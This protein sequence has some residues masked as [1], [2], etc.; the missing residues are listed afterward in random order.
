MSVAL[1]DAAE[2]H[3]LRPDDVVEG[4]GSDASLGLANAEAAR[5]LNDDGPN[6]LE[7]APK[8]SWIGRLS[9]ELR[10]PLVGLL[11]V[12]VAISLAAWLLEGRHGF[13]YDAIAITAILT[14]NAVI[15]AVQSHR[16]DNA[17]AALERLSAAQ[18]RVVRDG[19]HRQ[20]PAT[21]VVVGDL[22]ALRAGDTLPADVRVLSA[23][24]LRTAE[25]SLTGESHPVDK[26]ADPV[27]RSLPIADRASM[28]YSGTAVVAGRGIGVVVATGMTTEVGQIASMLIRTERLPTPLE[29]D[30][31]GLGRL[32]GSLVVAVAIVVMAVLAMTSDVSSASDAIDVLLLG[33]SLAVAAVPEGLPAVL[34]VVLAISVQRMASRNALVKRLLSAETL[35]AATVICTDKTGTLTRNEM[36]VR[37]AVVGRNRVDIGGV[38]Y[39]PAGEISAAGQSLDPPVERALAVLLG[40]AA[41][42]GDS[43]IEAHPDGWR[44]VG[45]PT[46][47]A[48]VAAAR[49]VGDVA[50]V[51][52]GPRL[53]EL[54][55]TSDRKRMSVLLSDTDGDIM[56]TKGAP[57]VLIT[58]CRTEWEDTGPVVLTPER[59]K[60][61]LD[62]VEALAAEGLRTM[63][64]ARRTDVAAPLAEADETEL[65]WLGAVGIDDPP[66]PEAGPAV[67]AAHDSGIRVVMV[68]GD[69]P[70]TATRIAQLV[71]IAVPGDPVLTGPEL[72][73]LDDAQ[74]AA[75]AM[76]TPVFARVTPAHKLRL[77][78]AMQSQGD[79]VAM[80]G[81]GVNDAPALKAADLGTAMGCTGT[82]VAREASEMILLDDNFATIVAAVSE[83][84]TIWHNIRSFLR[85]LLSSNVG[86]VFTVLL[87]IVFASA[88]GLTGDGVLAPLTASQILWI[89]LLTDAAPAMALGVD[90]VDP[91]VMQLP[92]RSPTERIV[93]ARMQRGIVVIGITMAVVTLVMFDLQRSG[94]LLGGSS[95]LDHARTAGFTV[96]VFA[97][98]FNAFN[99]RSDLVSAWHGWARNRMLLGAAAL[100]VL[101][102][103]AVVHVPFL[104]EAFS[105][106]PLA[107]RD[108]ILCALL[109]SVVLWVAELRKW[110][111]RRSVTAGGPQSRN[112]KKPA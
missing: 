81:D 7:R 99:A 72:D 71:G 49:K 82:D 105:T 44:A 47:A 60:W 20:V 6:A 42:A 46:E 51:P 59:R 102:Q 64:V 74:L 104:N 34:S 4:L 77:V 76:T 41:V 30:I 87:G 24:G 21:E 57:D 52:R 53:S 9:R 100:A 111:L 33:V 10:D 18:A 96:L 40:S 19:L 3:A 23:F 107:L 89:N 70:G 38:G 69:H 45:N 17:A 39:E 28:A 84:R 32:L 80:T 29:R 26:A 22:V 67:R 95:D 50:A 97:Q 31:A 36:M 37:V 106:S 110:N 68:T 43:D 93:D 14:L 1:L 112:T 109:A 11:V 94:G 61:W 12:A 8:P 15:G 91:L 88:I 62:H 2:V 55:F 98:V 35:G 66:R 103:V 63:A 56:I 5:R 65:E 79:V 54:G 83:G 78:R 92:P 108:W 73:H 16:A 58:R 90:P 27:A 75:K 86:E 13:P 48:L 101:L 85:Y 25:A